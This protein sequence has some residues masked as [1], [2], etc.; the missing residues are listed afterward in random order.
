MSVD[1]TNSRDVIVVSHAGRKF[2]YTRDSSGIGYW[3]CLS[4]GRSIYGFG[5]GCVVPSRYWAEITLS[6]KNQGYDVGMTSI[7]IKAEPTTS[8]KKIDSSK[9]A[10]SN[11]ECKPKKAKKDEN[12]G[13]IRIFS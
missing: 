6:A 5:V 8:T 13:I 12:S 1:S 2:G 4:S 3:Y 10:S 11:L 7:N 9:G